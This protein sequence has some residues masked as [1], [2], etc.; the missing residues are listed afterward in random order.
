MGMKSYSVMATGREGHRS[1]HFFIDG[2]RVPY[3]WYNQLRSKALSNGSIES[4]WTE[5]VGGLVRQH[6]VYRIND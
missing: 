5:R 1:T 3:E 2:R 6:S 4:M